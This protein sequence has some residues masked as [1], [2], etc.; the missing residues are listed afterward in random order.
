MSQKDCFECIC[1]F[2]SL[3]G[4]KM[5]STFA[6]LLSRAVEDIFKMKGWS[7]TKT[8]IVKLKKDPSDEPIKSSPRP[9]LE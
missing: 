2:E 3:L 4:P 6:S 1:M 9:M 7:A 8:N 5:K